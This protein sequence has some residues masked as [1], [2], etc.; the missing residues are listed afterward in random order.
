[1]KYL[2]LAL[3][4]IATIGCSDGETTVPN[5]PALIK[6]FPGPNQRMGHDISIEF[7]SDGYIITGLELHGSQVENQ[8]HIKT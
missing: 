8:T 4:L 2:P 3:L 6:S 1:M 5:D 7:S